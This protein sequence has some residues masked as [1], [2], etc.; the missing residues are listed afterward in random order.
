M[1]HL[2]SPTLEQEHRAPVKEMTDSGFSVREDTREKID[3]M[4]RES[5]RLMNER[6]RRMEWKRVAVLVDRCFFFIYLFLIV[7][8]LVLFFPWQT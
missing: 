6:M 1:S 8:S 4:S 3:E 2:I 7:I 5:S